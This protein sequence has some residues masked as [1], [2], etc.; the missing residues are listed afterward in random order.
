M[1]ANI[2]IDGF[3]LYYGAVKNT[4]YKWLDIGRLFA[5]LRPHDEIQTIY[6]FTAEISGSHHAHQMAYL[7]ALATLPKLKII[8][9]K[10]KLKQV[11][12]GVAACKFRC[13]RAFYVPEEKRT[14]VQMALQ[15][16]HD[17]WTDACD[18]F[19]LVSGDSDL[20][21]AVRAVKSIAP[22]KKVV[23]YIP[24]RNEKRG[25]ALELRGTADKARILPNE[26]IRR[27][28]FPAKIPDGFGDF[29]HKPESW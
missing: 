23:V 15:L 13:G 8:L 28:Q 11:L 17:A 21:P 4:R 7:S 10:Y 19:I 22:D 9:G 29:V 26:L 16:T 2:Y 6:Y 25:A 1:R 14:D 24:A 5:M 18:R 27:A 20:V 3:N 12:C